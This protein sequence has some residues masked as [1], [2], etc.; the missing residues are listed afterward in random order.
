MVQLGG[1]IAWKT[2]QIRGIYCSFQ[3]LDLRGHGFENTTEH[4]AIPC[5]CL[6][7]PAVQSAA[8]VIIPQHMA[9]MYGTPKGE[10]TEHLLQ[11]VR[12]E[13][14]DD[15]AFG[16]ADRNAM[17]T[18]ADIVIE[19]LPDLICMPSE[20]PETSDV[21]VKAPILGIEASASMNGHVI[22]QEVL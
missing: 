11:R 1:A 5:M 18:I 19:G 6:F 14:V 7:R 8:A 21:I 22:H 15:L 20:P 13:W 12:D 17:R 16:R 4:A 3:W 2:R 9:F 10:V